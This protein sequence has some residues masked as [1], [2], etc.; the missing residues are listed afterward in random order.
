MFHILCR[1]ISD[2]FAFVVVEKPR[3]DFLFRRLELGAHIVLLADEYQL[4]RRSVVIVLQE[5]MHAEPEILEIE[6]GKIVAVN[7][8]RVEVVL[9]EI[10]TILASLLV[11][12]PD[13]SGDQKDERRD[14][15]RDDVDRD[16]V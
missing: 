3:V 5:I 14:N 2:V 16:I 8:K 13:K 6:L 11:F 9:F 12:P 1:V 15:R 7:R 10:P 4:S